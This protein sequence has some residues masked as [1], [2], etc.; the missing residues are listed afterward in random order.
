M[1]EL[2]KLLSSQVGDVNPE[3]A[4][5]GAGLIFQMV[6][7]HLSPQEF[8]KVQAAVP[9]SQELIQAAPNETGGGLMGALGGLAS[10]VGGENLGQLASLAGGF[11]KL[12][13]SPQLVMKFV[14]IIVTYVQQQGGDEVA[15]LV[16][17]VLKPAE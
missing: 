12:G 8:G 9:E 16:Q 13:I 11:Q 1:L 2:V 4:K 14:P 5:G 3:Q 10:A 15:K 6:Q 17:G 7:K